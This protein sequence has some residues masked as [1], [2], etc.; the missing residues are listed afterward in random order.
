[1]IAR[2]QRRPR[3]GRRMCDGH[4]LAVDAGVGADGRRSTM[5]STRSRSSAALAASR[6]RSQLHAPAR[7]LPAQAQPPPPAPKQVE[8]RRPP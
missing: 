3:V 1:M 7:T 6:S 5:T 2:Y 4:K 8:P